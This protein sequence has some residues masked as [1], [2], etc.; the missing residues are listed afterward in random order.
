MRL[1]KAKKDIRISTKKLSKSN[2]VPAQI[3]SRPASITD[4]A[5]HLFFHMEFHPGD[6]TRNQVRQLYSKECEDILKAEIDIEQF[7]L[8]YSHRKIIG[9][10]VAK[11]KLFEAPGRVSKFLTGELM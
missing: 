8:A 5:Q 3:A 11:T 4:P 9:N 2:Q 7:T 10:I 6:I 1:Q